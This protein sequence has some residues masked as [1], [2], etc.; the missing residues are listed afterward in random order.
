MITTVLGGILALGVAYFSKRN[1]PY[2]EANA[3]EKPKIAVTPGVEVP[4]MHF[5]PDCNV[6]PSTGGQ[7]QVSGV[8]KITTAVPS[9]WLVTSPPSVELGKGLMSASTN[10]PTLPANIMNGGE[11]KIPSQIVEVSLGSQGQS[12]KVVISPKKLNMPKPQVLFNGKK[13][14][15]V[16]K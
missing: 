2:A 6:L 13:T 4:D 3:N 9:G 15:W 16:P 8:E 14:P 1:L 10:P 7:I 5:L 11:Y 12:R